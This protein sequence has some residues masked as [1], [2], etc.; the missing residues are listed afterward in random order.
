[1]ILTG[2]ELAWMMVFGW[3]IGRLLEYLWKIA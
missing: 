1:M 3:F 2:A